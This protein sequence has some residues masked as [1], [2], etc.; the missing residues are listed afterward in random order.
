[1]Q[2]LARHEIDP[3]AKPKNDGELIGWNKTKQLVLNLRDHALFHCSTHRRCD[4]T[5]ASK[6]MASCRLAQ[7]RV[8]LVLALP[9]D[10]RYSS[11]NVSSSELKYERSSS[12]ATA[13]KLASR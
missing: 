3:L 11:G 2:D 5:F 4:P 1:M 8:D 9:V 13:E 6:R 12:C 7:V 10:Y